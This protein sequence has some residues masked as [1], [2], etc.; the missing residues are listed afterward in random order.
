MYVWKKRIMKKTNPSEK[1]IQS[2]LRSVLTTN[3]NFWK[4]N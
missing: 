1:K 2:D 4:S 3:S